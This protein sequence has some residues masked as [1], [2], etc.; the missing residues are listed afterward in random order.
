LEALSEVA[1]IRLEEERPEHALGLFQR[2]LA[3][4]SSRENIHQEVMKLY[5]SLGRRSEAAAHYQRLIDE[6]KR[7]GK[8]PSPETTAVYQSIIAQ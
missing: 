7:D 2:V 3:E 1:R 4:D 6:L 5:V 8:V